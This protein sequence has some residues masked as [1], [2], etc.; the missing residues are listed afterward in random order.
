MVSQKINQVLIDDIG[1]IDVLGTQMK[2][3]DINS[4]TYH[5]DIISCVK[6]SDIVDKDAAL[7]GYLNKWVDGIHEQDIRKSI[8]D[9]ESFIPIKRKIFKE[10]DAQRKTESEMEGKYPC[11]S[12]G[13]RRTICTESQTRAS[14]EPA[15]ITIVCNNAKCKL[16]RKSVRNSM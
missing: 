15:T 11:S 16:F 7:T 12:C 5:Y 4:G 2:L 8:F 3:K 6:Y 14:D 1:E 13:G 9:L 10:G